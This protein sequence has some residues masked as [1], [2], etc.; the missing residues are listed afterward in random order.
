MTAPRV[1]GWQQVAGRAVARLP[2]SWRAEYLRRQRA[3]RR[4][5]RRA[6]EALGSDRL[7]HP[8]L[9]DLDRKLAAHLGDRRDGFFV[10]AGGNDGFEQSNT[11]WLE[12]F[13]GWR[14][15]LVEPVP[16]LHREC[17]LERPG[18]HV[19]R[20]ALVAEP[21]PDGGEIELRYGGLMTV[22]GGS[23]GSEEADAAYVA[24]AFA[25]GFDQP[26]TFKAPARTLSEILDEAGVPPGGIDLLSLDVEGYEP[27]VLAGLDLDR[28]APELICVEIRDLPEGRGPIEAV[29]GE[30]YVW[31]EALSPFDGL[32]RRRD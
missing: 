27:Q 8:A 25:L 10:E 28:H 4:A 22:V 5:A 31:V 32:Y 29:L 15:V 18:A 24:E 26:F 11:Y 9:H 21:H 3:R 2:A 14:G 23:K 16:H 20:A 17:V 30:R 1:S 6:E 12:R 19:A 13:R 7:S